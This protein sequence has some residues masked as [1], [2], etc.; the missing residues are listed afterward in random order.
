MT[1]VARKRKSG[2]FDEPLTVNRIWKVVAFFLGSMI[3]FGGALTVWNQLGLPRL[4]TYEYVDTAIKPISTKV[5][6]LNVSNLAGRV[7][8][9]KQ[10]KQLQE[11]D[12][13]KLEVQEHTTKDPTALQ[14]IGSQK[15]NLTNA[16]SDIDSQITRLN[17][18]LQSAQYSRH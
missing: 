17:S 12:L 8:V 3:A 4:A 11:N 15:K 1:A 7:E 16:I 14:I 6:D 13:N 5:D 2:G 18:Q 9:L 10:G